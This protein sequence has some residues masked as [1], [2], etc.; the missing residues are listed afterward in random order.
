MLND[1]DLWVD[2]GMDCAL[3]DAK[4]GEYSSHSRVD[5]VEWVIIRNPDPGIYRAKLVADQIYSD[6][7]AAIAWQVIRGTTKPQLTVTADKSEVQV[8]Q[9]SGI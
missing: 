7:R 8:G 9:E 1:I 4:C 6:N 3:T 5:N 2:H